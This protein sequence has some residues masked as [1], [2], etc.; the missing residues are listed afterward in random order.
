MKN[1]I[2][3]LVTFGV[4]FVLLSHVVS[5]GERGGA[6]SPVAACDFPSPVSK[7]QMTRFFS[8]SQRVKEL[9][10]LQ[11]WLREMEAINFSKN[12]LDLYLIDHEEDGH[13]YLSDEMSDV[14]INH[15][16]SDWFDSLESRQCDAP[17]NGYWNFI[18]KVLKEKISLIHELTLEPE[19]KD[20]IIASLIVFT[21]N[22]FLKWDARKFLKIP[23][24]L[25]GQKG[26]MLSA[27]EVIENAISRSE[28]VLCID[29]VTLAKK[30]F[31]VLA[32][33]IDVERHATLSSFANHASPDKSRFPLMVGHNFLSLGLRSGKIFTVE[34]MHSPKF[35]RKKYGKESLLCRFI[36]YQRD[37]ED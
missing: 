35:L 7:D 26:A 24:L 10:I 30:L 25:L 22:F 6:K 1:F 37:D 36:L 19:K 8:H 18:I 27:P 20:F 2:K 32:P 16:L 33:H 3:N 13:R 11:R 29:Y 34:L 4:L 5:A 9:F 28:T 12:G 14:I 15:I 31:E 21:T 23:S 17:A